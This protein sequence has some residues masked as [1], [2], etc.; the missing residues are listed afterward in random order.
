MRSGRGQ[1]ERFIK[2]TGCKMFTEKDCFNK[3]C[4]KC[5]NNKNQYCDFLKCDIGYIIDNLNSIDYKEDDTSES[6]FIFY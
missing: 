1:P 5:E 6:D 4:R 3:D 2:K